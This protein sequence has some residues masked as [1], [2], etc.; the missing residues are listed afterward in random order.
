MSTQAGS[1]EPSPAATVPVHM[2]FLFAE[3]E[4]LARMMPSLPAGEE[5][6]KVSDAI[7]IISERMDE[8]MGV[9]AEFRQ[10][11]AREEFDF[12]YGA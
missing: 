4:R 8:V 9:T 6:S 1:L 10:A 3:Y 7:K 5:M 2:A 11:E 12:Y